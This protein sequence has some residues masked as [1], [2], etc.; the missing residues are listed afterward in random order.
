MLSRYEAVYS[1]DYQKYITKLNMRLVGV[2]CLGKYN[3][4]ITTQ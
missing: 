1:A 4:K 2:Y 3:F